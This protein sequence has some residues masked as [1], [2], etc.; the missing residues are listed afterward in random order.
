MPAYRTLRLSAVA[1]LFSPLCSGCSSSA[2]ALW[3][4]PLSLSASFWVLLS[5]KIYM[6]DLESALHY[7]L[8]V[9][10]G[11]FSVLEGQRLVALKKFMA[12]LAQ[13][14]KAPVSFVHT[15]PHRI[16]MPPCSR[17]YARP[18][19]SARPLPQEIMIWLDIQTHGSPGPPWAAALQS[20]SYLAP[21]SHCQ[22]HPF[23]ALPVQVAGLGKARCPGDGLADS[24]T[25]ALPEASTT[26]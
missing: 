22:G 15:A 13:V 5:S 25:V 23:P 10:V 16:S 12:V 6:A 1:L 8:R 3:L 11:K 21:G 26:T 18:E 2:P 19:G 9:E 4:T 24:A 17:P 20:Q 14:S 7:I